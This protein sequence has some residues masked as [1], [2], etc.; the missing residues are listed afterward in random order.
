MIRSWMRVSIYMK[1]DWFSTLLFIE[2]KTDTLFSCNIINFI[3]YA[4]KS[5][6]IISK[7]DLLPWG[8]TST[9]YCII[10]LL[11]RSG[12]KEISLLMLQAN[13]LSVANIATN[14]R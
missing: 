11:H 6:N 4:K 10:I 7:Y 2:K 12:L 9:V 13:R 1:S 14:K 8:S 5:N 3:F